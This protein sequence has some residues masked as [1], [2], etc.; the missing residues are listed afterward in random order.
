MEIVLAVGITLLSVVVVLLLAHNRQLQRSHIEAPLAP[1]SH[2]VE[3]LDAD[4]LMAT[5]DDPIWDLVIDCRSVGVLNEWLQ[6]RPELKES[7]DHRKYGEFAT[8]L[9]NLPE[10][11]QTVRGAR[12]AVRSE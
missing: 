11:Q 2:D 4:L 8:W 5:S 6:T 10:D 9:L 7:Q 3:A 12:M 1:R